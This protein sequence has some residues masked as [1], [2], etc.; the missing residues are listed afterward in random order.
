MRGLK[1]FPLKSVDP[2]PGIMY[3]M[4]QFQEGKSTHTELQ[5]YF[6]EVHHSLLNDDIDDSFFE[7][8]GGFFKGISSYLVYNI[9][10]TDYGIDVVMAIT[11]NDCV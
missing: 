1:P 3:V 5:S 2:L 6:S 10:K 7:F 4:T 8:N 9:N 11:E